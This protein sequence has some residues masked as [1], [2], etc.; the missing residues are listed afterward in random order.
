[1]PAGEASSRRGDKLSASKLYNSRGN[2]HL[3]RGPRKPPA[4]IPSRGLASKAVMARA[5]AQ[6]ARTLGLSV[7]LLLIACVG[8]AA[9]LERAVCYVT[10]WGKNCRALDTGQPCTAAGPPPPPGHCRLLSLAPPPPPSGGAMFLAMHGLQS[11]KPQ[12]CNNPRS[13]CRSQRNT[14]PARW[15]ARPAGGRHSG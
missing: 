9:A 4:S 12:H 15:A 7:L 13:L 5:A 1:M 10:N 2:R 11:R 6:A 3:R 14:A 8:R